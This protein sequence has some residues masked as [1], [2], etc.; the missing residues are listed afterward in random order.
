SAPTSAWLV[1]ACDW[2]LLGFEDMQHLLQNRRSDL[3]AT[4]Y[5]HQGRR[6]P[7]C[8]LYEP[9]FLR[10]AEASWQAGESSLNRLLQAATAWEIPALDAERWVNA[11]DETARQHVEVRVRQ[12]TSQNLPHQNAR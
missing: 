12:A 6:E 1:L 11:N 10:A 3:S 7:L 4:S 5:L 9:D 2:P 8:S